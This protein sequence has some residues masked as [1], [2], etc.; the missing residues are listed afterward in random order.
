MS[1]R[2]SPLML[3]I[4]SLT[5]ML[6]FIGISGCINATQPTSPVSG[7]NIT[8]N[9]LP[10]PE[11]GLQNW[12]NAINAKDIDRLYALSPKEIRDQVTLEQFTLDNKNNSI[13]NKGVICTQYT[14]LNKTINQTTATISARLLFQVP[15]SKNT[16]QY[17]SVPV[18]YKFILI[19]EQGEWKVWTVPFSFS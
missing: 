8:T 12:I 4:W 6:L 1:K 11:A 7:I 2:Y 16:T 14:L 17:T 10:D 3:W 18:Y 19:F 5:A 13:L 9:S 15:D